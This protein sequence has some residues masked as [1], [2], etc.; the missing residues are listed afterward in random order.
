MDGPQPLQGIQHGERAGPGW[1]VPPSTALVL[2]CQSSS[3]AAYWDFPLIN[4][5]FCFFM[6]QLIIRKPPVGR[7]N[8]SL[9]NIPG[10]HC[11]MRQLSDGWAPWGGG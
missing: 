10:W 3:R 8:I 6:S 7:K 11:W 9:L 1:Q 4:S 2:G 5:Q